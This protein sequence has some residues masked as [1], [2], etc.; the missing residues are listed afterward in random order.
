MAGSRLLGHTVRQ[1]G[2]LH[3]IRSSTVIIIC[4]NKCQLAIVYTSKAHQRGRNKVS[5]VLTLGRNVNFLLKDF[6][7]ENCFISIWSITFK[8]FRIILLK[9]SIGLQQISRKIKYNR[10]LNWSKSIYFSNQ[11]VNRNISRICKGY[12]INLQ[13]NVINSQTYDKCQNVSFKTGI[14]CMENENGYLTY[15]VLTLLRICIRFGRGH[16]DWFYRRQF[17]RENVRH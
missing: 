6:L 16:F 9:S 11:N 10:L 13:G 14:F 4:T 5:K 7:F 15:S 12:V 2:H 3:Q 1:Y 8:I 17:L